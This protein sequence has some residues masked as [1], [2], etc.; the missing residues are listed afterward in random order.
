ML[1]LFR[2]EIMHLYCCCIIFTC[3]AMVIMI[4]M[5][6][7]LKI[8]RKSILLGTI[9]ANDGGP[10]V[11][12]QKQT[13]YGKSKFITARANSSR[14]EQ[15]VHG[16][17]KLPTARANSWRQEQ[18]FTHGKSKFITAKNKNKKTGQ[19]FGQR[20]LIFA[21]NSCK[22]YMMGAL[23]YLWIDSIYFPTFINCNFLS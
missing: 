10:Q 9:S 16:K 12:R 15:I 14:Q 5:C 4:Y 22:K 1:I 21:S 20:F 8:W 23:N 2:S 19:R 18:I 13:H 17:S 3:Y 6:K 7:Q 11:P